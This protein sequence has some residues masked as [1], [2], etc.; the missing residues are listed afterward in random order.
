MEPTV[1][2][3]NMQKLQDQFGK[4]PNLYV[5]IDEIGILAQHRYAEKISKNWCEEDAI[6]NR[7]LYLAA[8]YEMFK[9]TLLSKNQLHEVGHHECKVEQLE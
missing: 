3:N 7:N 8:Q 5:V 4:I 9:A 1:F 6:T 2:V